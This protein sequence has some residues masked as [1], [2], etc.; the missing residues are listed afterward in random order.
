MRSHPHITPPRDL[1][2]L[3]PFFRFLGAT[4]ANSFVIA[5]GTGPNPAWPPAARIL[6]QPSQSV[7]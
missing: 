3:L 7:K 6:T 5:A 4:P 2:G 1:S